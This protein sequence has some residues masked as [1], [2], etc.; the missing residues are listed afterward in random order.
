[1]DYA[2]RWCWALSVCACGRLDGGP[3]VRVAAALWRLLSSPGGVRPPYGCRTTPRRHAVLRAATWRHCGQ[4]GQRSSFGDFFLYQITLR[5]QPPFE[6]LQGRRVRMA[7]GPGRKGAPSRTARPSNESAGPLAAVQLSL[8]AKMGSFDAVF[9]PGGPEARLG[10]RLTGGP[11]AAAV[12]GSPIS[13]PFLSPASF[14]GMVYFL[15]ISPGGPIK[16]YH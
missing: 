4:P 3:A 10:V 12:G 8:S 1:M 9:S 13:T 7:L 11:D 5:T 2:L 6:A 16:R 14:L 15:I